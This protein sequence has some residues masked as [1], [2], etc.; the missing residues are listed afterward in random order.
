MAVSRVATSFWN[1][2]AS[3]N[4]GSLRIFRSIDYPP[5]IQALNS[6]KDCDLIV[7]R[8]SIDR[9]RTGFIKSLFLNTKTSCTADSIRELFCSGT[10]QLLGEA[11]LVE[12]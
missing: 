4:Q 8:I 5:S 9:S 6:E 7:F 10:L 1:K 11:E 3:N 2:K 12:D